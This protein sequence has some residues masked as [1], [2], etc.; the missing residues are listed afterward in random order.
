MTINLLVIRIFWVPFRRVY[1][2]L[3]IL[4][5]LLLLLLLADTT[6]RS[7]SD[8]FCY[9]PL[10]LQHRAALNLPQPGTAALNHTLHLFTAIAHN[11]TQHNSSL[12]CVGTTSDF[13]RGRS[14]FDSTSLFRAF[15]LRL[16]RPRPCSH[17][18][19]KHEEAEAAAAADQQ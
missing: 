12:Y 17:S 2:S 16:W 13:S 6:I 5:R 11:T 10:L 3:F 19:A 4:L 18:S 1:S 14:F 9:S 15:F 7:G 8:N